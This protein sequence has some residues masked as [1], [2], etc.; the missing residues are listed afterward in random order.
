[1][2]FEY[3]NH[4]LETLD[5][6]QVK[7]MIYEDF[8][9]INDIC[10][11]KAAA[12]VWA[13]KLFNI[14]NYPK[15]TLQA[16]AMRLFIDYPEA[17]EYA[18]TRYCIYA[19]TSKISRHNLPCQD[20]RI[21]AEKLK[22][23]EKEIGKYFANSAKGDECHVHFY[24]EQERAVVLVARGSYFRAVAR[25]EGGAIKVESFRPAAEDVLMY[26]R[27]TGQLCIQTPF[28]TDREQ[29]IRS[30][31]SAIIG[32]LSLA[33]NPDRDKIYTLDPILK[34]SFKWEGNEYIKSIIPVEAKLKIKGATEAVIEIRSKDL[35][36]TLQQYLD[37][38]NLSFMEIID[39]KFR[40]IIETQGKEEKVTFE[41]APPYATDLP[42]KKHADIISA[43]LKENGVQLR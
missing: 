17:F 24:D 41:I 38:A 23:F 1:M 6:E 37:S 26:D 14:Q 22:T 2:Y 40:F 43:Y 7:E 34:G 31:A 19:S 3:V 5:D 20:L 12:L 42:K 36:L 39:M 33:D 16:L 28:P 18:W 25:W 35:R 32:D 8:R 21:D 30:F 15:E 11:E 27:K 9:R 4:L 10:E 29:Y 13:G